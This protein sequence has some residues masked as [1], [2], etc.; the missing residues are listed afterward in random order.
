MANDNLTQVRLGTDHPHSALSAAAAHEP[1]RRVLGEP[2]PTVAELHLVSDD[3][4]R[5]ATVTAYAR[6][7]REG[8]WAAELRLYAEAARYDRAH[9]GEQPLFDELHGIEMF[10]TQ[11]SEAA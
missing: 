4:F 7:R 10:G 6:A 5:A 1:L 9:P 2:A 11:Y 8:D 3:D